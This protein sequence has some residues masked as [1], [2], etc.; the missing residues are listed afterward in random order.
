MQAYRLEMGTSIAIG[1]K[2][3]LYEFWDKKIAK[4]INSAAEGVPIVNLAS[5]EYFKSVDLKTV[6]SPV[7]NIHFKEFKNET[8]QVVGFF[9]KQARGHMTDFAIKNRITDPKELKLFNLERYE[10]ADALSDETD[11][12]FLR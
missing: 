2:K 1:S 6:N 7:I 8:Y 12:V 9:A 4:A 10:F 11:W 5:Q 3:N